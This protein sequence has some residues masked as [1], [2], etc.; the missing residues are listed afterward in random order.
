MKEKLD[1]KKIKDMYLLELKSSYEIARIMGV[2]RPTITQR[3]KKNG[4]QLRSPIKDVNKVLLIDLYSNKKLSLYKISKIFN[5]SI[6]T[7]SRR[8]RKMNLTPRENKRSRIDIDTKKMGDLYTNKKESI[9]QISIIMDVS[10]SAITKR[11]IEMGIQIRKNDFYMKGNTPPNKLKLDINKIKEMYLFQEKTLKEIGDYFNISSGT[12]ANRLEKMGVKRRYGKRGQG[13]KVK[14][15]LDLLKRLYV[16]ERLSSTKIAKRLDV[17]A[18]T[19]CKI[20]KEH[21]WLRSISKALKERWADPNSIY[22]DVEWQRRIIKKLMKRPTSYE[23]KIIDLCKKYNLP[24]RYVGDGEIIIDHINPDFISYNGRKLI[25]ETYAKYWHPK[26]YEE[27]RAKRFAKCD[28]KVLF[29]NDN[30]LSNKNWENICLNKIKKL[31]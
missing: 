12:I 1:E 31:L 24:F 26:N 13:R 30:D 23:Q 22:N 8:V 10:E 18:T 17:S 29:L 5:V 25:I 20:L 11:I 7:I 19:I 28:Y 6:N 14:F 15:D 9:R 27:I 4:V 2:S 3:L 16:N 21:K